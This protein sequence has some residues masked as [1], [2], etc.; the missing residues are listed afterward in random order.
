MSFN[1]VHISIAL[2]LVAVTV[3]I[4]LSGDMN[5]VVVWKGVNKDQMLK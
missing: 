3:L 4:I 1:C 5:A 2:F